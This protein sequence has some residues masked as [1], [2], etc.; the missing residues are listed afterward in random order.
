MNTPIIAASFLL[1]SLNPKFGSA[2]QNGSSYHAATSNTAGSVKIASEADSRYAV[3]ATS[4]SKKKGR[5]RVVRIQAK[6]TKAQTQQNTSASVA[7]SKRTSPHQSSPILDATEMRGG[8]FR[9]IFNLNP[10]REGFTPLI[11]SNGKVMTVRV[12]VY[13]KS[14]K[15]T[16]YYTSKGLAATGTRLVNKRSAAVDPKII[17]YGSRIILP[18]AGKELVAVDTGNAVKQR[19]AAK[20]LGKDVP[21]VDIYFD[22]KKEALEF[23]KNHPLFMKAVVVN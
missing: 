9:K 15:G 2:I 1:G 11:P 21:V 19:T 4:N 17:P 6:P 8:F 22:C 3:P 20:K 14:G 13:W 23:A 10:L 7:D 16:D 18:E 12:T 5:R